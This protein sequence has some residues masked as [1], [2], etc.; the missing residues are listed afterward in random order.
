[1][2]RLS[3]GVRDNETLSAYAVYN[4]LDADHPTRKI[5]IQLPTNQ[6]NPDAK[7]ALRRAFVMTLRLLAYN[8]DTWLADHFNAYLQDPNEYRAIMRNLMHHGGTITYTPETIT[9]TLDP[10]D[11]PR[12][13]RAL[14][15]LTDELNTIPAH[16]P[17]T[18]GRSTTNS[19][20]DQTSTHG[21]RLLQELWDPRAA[22]HAVTGDVLIDTV[23]RLAV[24]TDGAGRYVDPTGTP[25]C[26]KV[27]WRANVRCR[28]S[29]AIQ[30]ALAPL[31][32]SASTKGSPAWTSASP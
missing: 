29:S 20:H 10:H 32:P 28:G 17:A 26:E 15:C 12:V 6:I 18:P 31:V 30:D 11:T 27:P 16:G 25:E 7:R 1:M 9:V 21:H 4:V 3:G 22:Q 19:R 23:R 5:P 14:A 2:D 8:T 13:N 24:L